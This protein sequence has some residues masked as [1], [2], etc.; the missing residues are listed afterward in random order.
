MVETVALPVQGKEEILTA[1]ERGE[2]NAQEA[3]ERLAK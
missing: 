1:L 2:I 3:I